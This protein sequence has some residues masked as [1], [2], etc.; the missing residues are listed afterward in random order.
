MIPGFS[1]FFGPEKNHR[2]KERKL[3]LHQSRTPFQCGG[4]PNPLADGLY[5]IPSIGGVLCELVLNFCPKV[6]S[7]GELTVFIPKLNTGG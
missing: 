1:F 4:D 6:A 7:A 3:S 2:S 5:S